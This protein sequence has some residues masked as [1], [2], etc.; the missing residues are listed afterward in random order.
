MTQL[1]VKVGERFVEQQ[2]VRLDCD[3]TGDGD[4]LLLPAG[5]GARQPGGEAV[6]ADEFEGG[7]DPA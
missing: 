4:S 3:G 2:N 5:H 6:E 1:G 7:G